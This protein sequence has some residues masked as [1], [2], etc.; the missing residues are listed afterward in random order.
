MTRITVILVTVLSLA[1][2]LLAAQDLQQGYFAY[3][4]RDFAMALQEWMPLAEAG[5]AQFNLGVMYDNGRGV[6][7]GFAEAALRG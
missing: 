7:Q 4:A 2:A 6:L 3:Q 1:F 5:D